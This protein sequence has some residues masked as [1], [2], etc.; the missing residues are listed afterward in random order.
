MSKSGTRSRIH[1]LDELRGLFIVLMV[2]FHAFY[3]IGWEFDVELCREAFYFFK[4][5]QPFFAGCFIFICGIS[6]NFSHNNGKRGLQLAGIALLVSL[7]MWCAVFWRLLSPGSE[8]WF[9]I[10]HCLSACILLFDVLQPKLKY[11]PA[12]LG[13]LL[14]GVLFVICYHVPAV[15]YELGSYFGIKGLFTVDVPTAATN[16]PLLYGLG[17]CPISSTSDYFPLLP[18]FFCFLA[19]TFV[20]RWTFPKWTLRSRFPWLAAVGKHTLIIYVLHQPVLYLICEVL[21]WIFK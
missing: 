17:M 19:G 7:G 18:W 10:L 21:G 3:L 20:G 8:I 11:I 1:L 2:F 15:P 4:P 9:G 6:C 12:W 13:L 5:V 16:H 14:C